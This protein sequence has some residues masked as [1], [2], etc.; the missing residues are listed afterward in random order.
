IEI[1]TEQTIDGAAL[2][3]LPGIK[4]VR[5][6]GPRSL[7]VVAEDAGEAIPRVLEAIAAQGGEVTSSR[8]VRPSFDAVF[9]R[10]LRDG[11]ED[12]AAWEE[13]AGAAVAGARDAA[14]VR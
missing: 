6:V 1:E 5:Q 11:R 2:P 12:G 4:A 13:A 3:A 14:R 8:E 10:L 9:T 7:L